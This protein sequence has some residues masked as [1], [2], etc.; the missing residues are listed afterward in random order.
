MPPGYSSSILPYLG[1]NYNANTEGKLFGQNV[2][3]DAKRRRALLLA[4]L[5]QQGKIRQSQLSASDLQIAAPQL[6]TVANKAGGGI[7]SVLGGIG[8]FFGN[9]GSDIGNAAK[10]IGPGIASAGKGLVH[11]ILHPYIL[12]S[13][14]VS[15]AYTSTG[16]QQ[17][18]ENTVKPL[19]AQY[20]YTYLGQGAP[21]G[22]TLLGR[23]YQHPLGPILDAASVASL[24]LGG[25]AR[26]TAALSRA[27]ALGEDNLA[28]RA[29]VNTAR[30]PLVSGELPAGR[31][32]A[33]ETVPTVP[34]E[35]STRPLRRALQYGTD[36]AAKLPIV[37]KGISSL[38][39]R[40]TRN[41]LQRGDFSIKE[42]K[43]NVAA[44]REA[45]EPMVP[46]LKKLTPDE[47]AAIPL[48]GMRIN[49]PDLIDLYQGAV[50]EGIQGKAPEGQNVPHAVTPELPE[51]RANL[52][53]RTKALAVDPT[54]SKNLMNFLDK[55]Q[56]RLQSRVY[57]DVKDSEKLGQFIN[58]PRQELLKR[59]GLTDEMMVPPEP[60]RGTQSM[61]H[62]LN[63]IRRSKGE[64]TLPR[65][66]KG[67]TEGSFADHPF[68]QGFLVPTETNA[69]VKY[70]RPGR[71]GRL[72]G[73][74][75]G[76]Q[77]GKRGTFNP[78][79]V[80]IQD[81]FRTPYMGLRPDPEA[82]LAGVTRPDPRAFVD[83]LTKHERDTIEAA[84]NE[85]NVFNAA[86]K[87]KNGEAVQV[88][89]TWSQEK[90]QQEFGPDFVAVSPSVPWQFY[91]KEFTVSQ[92]LEKMSARGLDTSEI[93]ARAAAEAEDASI[94]TTLAAQRTPNVV[95][96]R[97]FAEYQLNLATAHLPY[98]FAA[99][100]GLARAM[101]FWRTHT[102]S[103]MP[104][105]A[106]NTG[107]GSFMLAS[108]KGISPRQYL[109]A[110]KLRA[111]VGDEA[112]GALRL[113]KGNQGFFD[114]PEVA[115]VN[116]ASIGS[117]DMLEMGA[118]GH[119]D[120]MNFKTGV[121]SRTIM[122]RVQQIE[123]HFRRASFVQ[124]LDKRARQAMNEQGAIISNVERT[125]GPRSTQE[126][127]DFVAENP[128]LTRHAIDDLNKFSYNFATLGPAE[129]R[130]VRQVVP[131]W[132]WY[133]FISGLAYRLP[134]DY[135][136][137]TDI[138]AH[139]GMLGTAETQA[140]YGKLPQWLLG[141]I[142]LTAPG[143]KNFK[144][145][146]TTGLN[147]FSQIFNPGGREGAMQGALQLGQGSPLI[148][149]ILEGYGTDTLRGGEVPISPQTLHDAGIAPDFWGSLVGIAGTPQAG[150][151]Y[152]VS[153]VAS[154]RRFLATILREFPYARIAE[155]QMTGGRSVYPESL[156]WSLRP[157][158]TKPES[159]FGGAGAD[160]LEQLIGIAPRPYDLTS[161][162]RLARKRALYARTRGRSEF[163][164]LVQ[165]LAGK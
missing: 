115:G 126:Y 38:Q 84:F 73:R 90:V 114:Q 3:A 92:A 23:I 117:W 93:M 121:I 65:L 129:R 95:V 142:P 36:Q 104:R 43:G 30:E 139:I 79:N 138:L 50:R 148:Q 24:G 128:E 16:N 154:G 122:R 49:S 13:P 57:P 62:I 7:G 6:G 96:P 67:Q 87:D 29:L 110:Q 15:S 132:G 165:N 39:E 86:V 131:F 18:I 68:E 134:V 55:Y 164:N 4:Q 113:G 77:L 140:Q 145:L 9:L 5:M 160:V 42:L 33:G 149:A 94:E 22:S 105:W 118:L 72:L 54:K 101:N 27:G 60:A 17:F 14:K 163:R 103:F 81:I 127:V 91:N 159:R 1:T 47:V 74:E 143:A 106:L 83:Y 48:I 88:P 124:S 157:M 82:V 161:Q 147:P 133:K 119:T 64:K 28:Y 63:N 156:P 61:G 130:Y 69:G 80:G 66:M 136:G 107:V 150:Q 99:A 51:S 89:G 53:D 162:Q 153:N 137:R 10:G 21:E 70:Y 85:E 44:N 20:A 34:R 135:P 25:V 41:A 100:R 35:F 97:K 141:A 144:Y 26:G 45:V 11:D 52:T 58:A 32:D 76:L 78:G 158:A 75:E 120:P 19:E 37:G 46:L 31:V 116:L 98:K 155:R 111:V 8:G 71:V 123:D 59:Y 2:A 56:E 102:L 152:S 125:K 109:M 146:S 40:I 112:K 151:D 108:I 12:Q